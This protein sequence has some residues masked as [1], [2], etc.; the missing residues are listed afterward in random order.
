MA[1][2]GIVLAVVF[3]YYVL[4]VLLGSS[5]SVYNSEIGFQS[6]L[7]EKKRLSHAAFFGRLIPLALTAAGFPLLGAFPV[8]GFL[9]LLAAFLLFFVVFK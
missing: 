5:L 1:I 7:E 8:A 2:V 4:E 9:M 6:S 3:V